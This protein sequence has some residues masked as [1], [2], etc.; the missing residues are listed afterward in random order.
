MSN[1]RMF[2]QSGPDGQPTWSAM[3][4]PVDAPGPFRITAL[5]FSTGCQVA[6][7]DV[8]VGDVWI[9]S[10][11]SNMYHT[12]SEVVRILCHSAFFS[13]T[14]QAISG[15]FPTSWSLPYTEFN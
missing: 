2:S 11:Q 9:C 7:D 14:E 10:G 4:D 15:V 12:M 1:V 5:Q 3:F 6:L 13:I 8:L